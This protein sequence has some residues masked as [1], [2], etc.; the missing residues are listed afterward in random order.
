MNKL[1]NITDVTSD[2]FTTEVVERSHTL[3]VLVDFWADWCGPCQMQM[4]MLKK[5]VD[6]YSGRFALAKVNTDEQRELARSFNI[7]SLPTMHLYKN[8]EIVEQI[9]AAQTESDMRLLLDRHIER[10]SDAIRQKAREAWEQGHSEQ[11]L[12]LLR[13]AQQA[14]PDNHPLTLD[15]I[16]LSIKA[17]LT[18]QAETLLTGLPHDVRN[19]TEA[20]R[21]RSLLEFTRTALAAAPVEALETTVREHADDLE[22]RY[23]LACRY[24]LEDRHADAMDAFMYILQHDRG[25]RDDAGR[26][27]LLAVFELLEN[28]GELA[29][30][31]RR[32]LFNALH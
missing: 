32:R 10:P 26:K 6:D 27:G 25:F 3:P 14:E 29:N 19:E 20:V 15:Y 31:Y 23:Q 17:G 9:I 24:V 21:L 1:N 7:R 5:L 18:E 22:S 13:E 12:T 2:T 28:E 30:S 11:A 8:G 4:P 16:D